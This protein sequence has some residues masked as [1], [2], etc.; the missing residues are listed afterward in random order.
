MPTDDGYPTDEE[1]RW[2]KEWS[3]K[4]PKGWLAVAKGCWWAADW[5]WRELT[6]KK[7]D[8]TYHVSTGGWSG[9]EEIIDAMQENVWCWA[10]TWESTRRGGHYVFVL[11][12]NLSG[13]A[14]KPSRV[15]AR[16]AE[17]PQP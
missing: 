5:G 4:D 6:G 1:L 8:L 7:G 3:D 15:G 16:D 9:N 12:A 17:E 10:Q 14:A 11:P 2:I 13:P